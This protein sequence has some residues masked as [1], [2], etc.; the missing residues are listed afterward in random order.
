MTAYCVGASENRVLPLSWPD[1]SGLCWLWPAND[2]LHE[3]GL[4]PKDIW[5]KQSH[6]QVPAATTNIAWW[7]CL[8]A[9]R[10]A[11]SLPFCD[12]E[13]Q[14]DLQQHLQRDERA[15]LEDDLHIR[16][17]Q[18]LFGGGAYEEAMAH[19]GMCSSANPVVLLRMFPSLAPGALLKP[20]AH[21]FPG[22]SPHLSAVPC[23]RAPESQEYFQQCALFTHGGGKQQRDM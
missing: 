19:F 2:S 15:A 16:Y 14:S 18:Q 1:S 17:G 9:P 21:L 4:L 6:A 23:Q 7:F 5:Q 8:P 20:V 3:V 12:T 22:E 10:P 13:R 11:N